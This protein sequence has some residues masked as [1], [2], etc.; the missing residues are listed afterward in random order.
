[1]LRDYQADQIFR[2]PPGLHTPQQTMSD[3]SKVTAE[4]LI[5]EATPDRSD[6]VGEGSTLCSHGGDPWV[7]KQEET[8]RWLDCVECKEVAKEAS[9][10]RHLLEM[11][12]RKRKEAKSRQRTN[13]QNSKAM[14]VRDRISNDRPA[15]YQL[16]KYYSG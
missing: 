13:R 8:V 11:V 7:Y 14:A 9:R 15:R 4:P 10:S 6:S 1:M 3:A 2:F 5:S 12:G 16:S